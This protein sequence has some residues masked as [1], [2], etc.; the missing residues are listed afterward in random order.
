MRTDKRRRAA[1]K[2]NYAQASSS[3]EEFEFEEERNEKVVSKGKKNGKRR[4]DVVPS[5]SNDEYSSAAVEDDIDG[6]ELDDEDYGSDVD[7]DVSPPEKKQINGKVGT[8]RKRNGSSKN[9]AI[10]ESDDF[11]EDSDEDFEK[12]VKKKAKKAVT[13]KRTTATK[14]AA[15]KKKEKAVTSKRTAIKCAALN[16]KGKAPAKKVDKKK[17]TTQKAKSSTQRKPVVKK[18]VK[19]KKLDAVDRL[20][21]AMQSFLW[22]EAPPLEDGHQWKSMEHAGV[23][24]PDEYVPHSVKLLYDGKPINLSQQEEEVAT[25]F[26]AT[27]PEGMHL[28]NAKTAPIYIKNFFTDFRNVL[29]KENKKIIKKF[30]KCDFS[31]IRE[32]LNEQKLVKKAIT[33]DERQQNK[34]DKQKA[35]FQYGYCLVDGHIEKVG[36]YNME[37]P[38]TF[39]GR[40]EHPKMGML[41]QRVKPEQVELNMS[42]S[43]AVPRCTVPG[44][45]WGE[46]RHDPMVQFLARW[47]ENINNLDK[48]MQLAAQSSFKGKSDR[49]K[50]SKAARLCGKI[51][52]IRAS[53]KSILCSRNIDERQLGT[54]MWVIDR[55]AL[56]VGGEK[57][58]DEEADTV[59][60]CSLRVEHLHFDPNNEG[61][62]NMEIKLEFLGKDSMLFKQTIDFGSELYTANHGM[63]EAVYNNFKLFC[64]KKK[65]TDEVFQTL[66]PAILN[67]HLK[68]IMD[69]L[70]AKVFRTYNASKTLQDEL[71]KTEKKNSWNELSIPEKVVEYNAANREVAILCNHQKSVSKAQ[72][73]TLENIGGKLATLK[74]QRLVLRDILKNLKAGKVCNVL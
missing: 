46:L 34:M 53:Y 58:T 73:T 67:Q 59:G 3:E 49:A 36:N 43:V 55:L 21:A 16:K 41:K 61:G 71:Q 13:P 27:D 5:S 23:A 19:I 64:K 24:F 6:E 47:K 72:E 70:T 37:P 56:R 66:T 14:C 57:D 40:G 33:D 8:S 10:S 20:N 32:H 18:E 68:G 39:K 62:D 69:G 29:S 48:Y 54:A 42:D 15:L 35:M 45:A 17:S 25:F 74:K 9:K 38:G 60:C 4:R 26:A 12:P 2:Q 22:W 65:T 51:D 28:G 7:E 1:V 30:D 50:Y 31:L 52:A 11:D 63:G 44:H